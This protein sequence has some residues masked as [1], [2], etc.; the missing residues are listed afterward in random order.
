VDAAAEAQQDYL[1]DLKEALEEI[2]AQPST[3]T[4]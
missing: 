2:K 1:R 4:R 3:S